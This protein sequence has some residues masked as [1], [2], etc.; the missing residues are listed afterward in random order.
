[1]FSIL[2]RMTHSISMSTHMN[3]SYEEAIKALCLTLQSNAAYLQSVQQHVTNDPNKLKDTEKYLLR[4]GITL[5]QLDSLSF[6]HVAGT[7]GK[8]TTCAF[9]EAILRQ[10]GF[11]T[12]FFSSP[13]LI[14]VRERIRINGEPISQTYFAR[15]FWKIYSRLEQHREHDSDMPTY[16][17][18]LTILMFHVF[19]EAN[20]DVAI[21]E[22][23]IGGEL[24]CTNVLRKPVC[25]GVT[26]LGLEHTSLLGNTL[27][28]IAHQKSGIFK[29]DA[30]AFTVPQAESAMR[31]LQQRVIER[32]CRSLKVVPAI[33][34]KKWNEIFS[35][36]NIISDV[37]RQNASL[38]IHMVLEWMKSRHDKLS[39]LIIDNEYNDTFYKHQNDKDE[40]S[41]NISLEKVAMAFAN[42]K[43]P[44]RT[45]I[46][47]TSVAD[48]F[49][50]GAHTVESIVHCISWFKRT[51]RGASSKFLIFNTTGDRNSFE[52]LKLL[53]PLNFDKAYFTPNYAGV[54]NVE[55]LS[56]YAMTYDQRKKCKKHCEQWGKDS[57]LKNS[58]AEVLVD[59]KRHVSS[60]M[61]NEEKVEVLV[62]GSLHLVGALLTILDPNLTMNS[63]F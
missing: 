19:L 20:V 24:D 47:K 21:V 60:Q 27:E 15:S 2:G 36:T 40:L 51:N 39:S 41:K 5:E 37:Q 31:V 56:D 58:V 53:A 18:F 34:N 16:F 12:G 55:N 25:V 38:S 22:V 42:C 54:A 26:S 10:Y 30:A 23:G 62:T 14:S 13:H 4:S 7:K 28:E 35:S 46:L 29:P 3:T 49:L 45:Q 59:I 17:K 48:F 11:S 32:R 50:D 8:G 6:I 61:T 63:D 52:L 57:I 44:G 33:Q 1:M 43:W 9:M